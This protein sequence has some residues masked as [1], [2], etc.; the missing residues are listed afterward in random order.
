MCVEIVG[1]V[2]ADIFLVS[3]VLSSVGARSVSSRTEVS[4]LLQN[5]TS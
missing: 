5:N 3:N 4:V 1:I 2:E